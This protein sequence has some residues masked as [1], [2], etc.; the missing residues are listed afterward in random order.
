MIPKRE[1]DTITYPVNSA[2]KIDMKNK[3]PQKGKEEK[4]ES[5]RHPIIDTKR[6]TVRNSSTG[7]IPQKYKTSI[8]NE[9]QNKIIIP[10]TERDQKNKGEKQTKIQEKLTNLSIGNEQRKMET[11][12]MKYLVRIWTKIKSK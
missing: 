4:T 1:G 8:G 6:N 7:D 5:C 2:T 9:I 11:G 10:V 3:K 12:I